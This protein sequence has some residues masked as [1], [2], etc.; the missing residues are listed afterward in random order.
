MNYPSNLGCQARFTTVAHP[1]TNGQAE[2]ANKSILHGL[3]KKLDN[4][5]VKWVDELHGVL[6]CL[7]N[8]E[9]TS[10]R[11]TTFILVYG[12]EV[13]LLV[14]GALHTHRLTTFKE[15]LNNATLREALDLVPPIHGG[16]FLREGLFKLRI[17]GLHNHAARVQPIQVGDLV[18]RRKLGRG[19]TTKLT[20][21]SEGP[22]KDTSQIRPSTYRLET[23][24]GTPIPRA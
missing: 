11:E 12:P 18:L 16:A 13:V 2:A 4:A 22:Y 3:Q 5:K 24:K 7:R 9:K 1:Q 8:T 10:T 19:K 15:E 17:I 21:N 14:R 6:W 20:A 23:P